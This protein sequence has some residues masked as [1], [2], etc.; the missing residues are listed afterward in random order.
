MNLKPSLKYL[1]ISLIT[2]MI[3]LL[4]E[5]TSYGQQAHQSRLETAARRSQNSA[6]TIKV[7]TGLPEDEAIPTQLFKRAQAIAVFPD[8]VQTH[9]L[10]SQGMK[11]YGVIC[12]RQSEGW[13]LPAY[14]AFG[15]AGMTLKMASFK[16]YDLIVLFMNE[17]TINRFH[18]GR[19]ELKGTNAGMAGPVGKLTL[20]VENDIRGANI[21]IYALIDGKLKGLKI[22]ADF[23]NDAVIN[24]DNNINKAVYGIKGREVLEGKAPTS[25]PT[26]SDMTAFR[27]ILKERFS[28]SK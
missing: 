15:G 21:I 7:I 1:I 6:K 28:V 12:R 27:D 14:Y 5:P 4:L 3:S 13:S 23:F 10:F 9:L 19:L 22:A 18:Q 16:S 25:L 11:G 17:N 20:E 8:V 26:I 24:P 2:V